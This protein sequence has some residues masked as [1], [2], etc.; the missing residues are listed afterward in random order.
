MQSPLN[1]P[2]RDNNGCATKGW[3]SDL[4]QPR[5]FFPYKLSS[6]AT[7]SNDLDHL[8]P[9]S[10]Q[11]HIWAARPET[12]TIGPGTLVSSPS[13]LTIFGAWIAWANQMFR[14][15]YVNG[16]RLRPA[17]LCTGSHGRQIFNNE[18]S[19]FHK[20]CIKRY[21]FKEEDCTVCLSVKPD[22]FSGEF[23]TKEGFLMWAANS[24]PQFS[25]FFIT[26]SLLF[27]KSLAESCFLETGSC[28]PFRVSRYQRPRTS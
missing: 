17:S 28:F 3:R 24:L 10:Q 2:L 14:W 23:C 8:F 7:N 1:S 22:G 11:H 25:A 27:N 20:F 13:L 12:S 19:D 26:W 21:F 9:V 4:T 16:S 18:R 15:D 5:L 6:Q